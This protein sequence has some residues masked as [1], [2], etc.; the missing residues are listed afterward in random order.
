MEGQRRQLQPTALTAG[1]STA[2]FPTGFSSRGRPPAV[3]HSR[4]VGLLLCVLET[5][6]RP[7]KRPSNY[8]NQE[9]F[10]VPSYTPVTLGSQS[11]VTF[12][13]SNIRPTFFFLLPFFILILL[14]VV[15]NIVVWGD[16]MMCQKVKFEALEMP[17]MPQF[18]IYIYIFLN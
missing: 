4:A 16:K 1:S 8:S 11:T 6:G 3:S 10:Q 9:G 5:F 7:S 18:C 13:L 2:W 15:N 14:Y 12:V 17:Q